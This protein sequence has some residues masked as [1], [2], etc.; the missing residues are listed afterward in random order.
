MLIVTL[1]MF[2]TLLQHATTINQNRPSVVRYKY[3]TVHVW[4]EILHSSDGSSDCEFTSSDTESEYEIFSAK[5]A[6][7]IPDMCDEQG[8]SQL[9]VNDQDDDHLN[10]DQDLADDDGSIDANDN[11]DRD[12][13]ANDY[14]EAIKTRCGAIIWK[15]ECPSKQRYA[16]QNILIEDCRV[17]EKKQFDSIADAFRHSVLYIDLHKLTCK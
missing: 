2:Q 10:N 3:K 9:Y 11:I 13:V 1:H 16:N 14:D 12:N 5:T 15:R 17:P 8:S 4:N 6:C 7:K